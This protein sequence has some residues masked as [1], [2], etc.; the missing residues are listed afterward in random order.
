MT[1]R[2]KVKDH[3]DEVHETSTQ[4]EEE[5]EARMAEEDD[6]EDADE[7]EDES[8]NSASGSIK[9]PIAKAV[10]AA[11]ARLRHTH[12]KPLRAELAQLR[13]EA[14]NTKALLETARSLRMENEFLRF[15]G[16]TF[17]DAGAAFKL[18]D[19]NGVTLEEDGGVTGME[20]AVRAVGESHP[21]LVR[22]D[23]VDD[24]DNDEDYEFYDT[25]SASGRPMNGRRKPSTP[26]RTDDATLLRKYPALRRR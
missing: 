14:G 2:K 25:G 12:I 13:Q 7:G 18:A 11:E 9:D 20:D 22:G 26:P 3:F 15:A 6:A 17:H 1:G 21:Y 19:L 8:G 10:A 24:D 23:L 5:A 16:G 4:Q